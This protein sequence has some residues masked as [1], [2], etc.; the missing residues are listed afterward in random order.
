MPESVCIKRRHGA[1]AAW[2]MPAGEVS[3]EE[4]EAA[5]CF[6]CCLLLLLL[7]VLL[8]HEGIRAADDAP[9]RIASQRQHC[10]KQAKILAYA[11][12]GVAS[13]KSPESFWAT[14]CSGRIS[15]HPYM[16]LS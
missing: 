3:Q 6:F 2:A 13:P 11:T 4:L 14:E 10:V 5:A 15:Y 1:V 16:A 9:E 7:Q 8:L 12:L